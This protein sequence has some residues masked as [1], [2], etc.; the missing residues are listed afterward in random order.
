MRSTI[1]VYVTSH[2]VNYNIKRIPNDKAYT[3][4]HIHVYKILTFLLDN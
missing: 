4:Y 1:Y 3:Q 2:I